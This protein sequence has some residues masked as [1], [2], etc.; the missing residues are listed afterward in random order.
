MRETK[1]RAWDTQYKRF[2]YFS[3]KDLYDEGCERQLEKDS[4]HLA[5]ST[6]YPYE[7]EEQYTGYKMQGKDVFFGDLVSNNY[8]TDREVLREVVMHKGCIMLKRVKGKSSLPKYIE[9]H[10]HSAFNYKI[11]GTTHER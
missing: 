8:K 6:D 5:I 9:I 11:I 2:F 7:N 3:L 4:K 10:A 1:F